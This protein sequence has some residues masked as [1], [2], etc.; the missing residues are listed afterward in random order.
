MALDVQLLAHE[1]DPDVEA[2]VRRGGERRFE[3]RS[4]G[5][6]AAGDDSG[7]ALSRQLAE[8]DRAVRRAHRVKE[9]HAVNTSCGG[10]RRVTDLA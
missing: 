8:D 5:R 3:S 2:P 10:R 7:A 6:G 1:G 9:P 4:R